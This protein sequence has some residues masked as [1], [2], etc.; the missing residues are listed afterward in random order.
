[1]DYDRDG[2]V[3]LGGKKISTFEIVMKSHEN[4]GEGKISAVSTSI[5]VGSTALQPIY[6][7]FLKEHF[8]ALCMEFLSFGYNC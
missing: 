8:L 6:L 1:M 5:S 7:C 2:K 3:G 4:V